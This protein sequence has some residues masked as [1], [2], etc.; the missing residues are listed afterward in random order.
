MTRQPA[1]RA[2]RVMGLLNA[3]LLTL[4]GAAFVSGFGT[5]DVHAWLGLTVT[6]GVIWHL[7]LHRSSFDRVLGR[8]F[9]PRAARVR[10][11]MALNLLF[12]IDFGALASSGVI[13]SQIYAPAVT[14]FHSGAAWIFVGLVGLHLIL[15]ARWIGTQV[16][17]SLIVRKSPAPERHPAGKGLSHP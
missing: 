1:G 10:L 13:V 6:A 15:N 12:V 7:A 8:W 14:R 9:E 17:R 2:A 11:R 3:G 16:R 5:L 4:S